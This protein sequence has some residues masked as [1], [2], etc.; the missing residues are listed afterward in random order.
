MCYRTTE[1]KDEVIISLDVQDS[2][3]SE[4]YVLVVNR[5]R[6]KHEF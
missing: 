5:N 1:R 6:G 2:I 4:K 3:W